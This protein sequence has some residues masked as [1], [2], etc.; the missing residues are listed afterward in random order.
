MLMA[1]EAKIAETLAK[2]ATSAIQGTESAIDMIKA[3][4]IY[5]TKLMENDETKKR[6]LDFYNVGLG[7]EGKL[8]DGEK[9]NILSYSIDPEYAKVFYNICKRDNIGHL[10]AQSYTMDLVVDGK[11]DSIKTVNDSVWIYNTQQKQF[12]NAIAEAKSISGYEVEV[13]R[14]VAEV[15]AKKQRLSGNP[16]RE[17][18]NMPI[19]RYVELRKDIQKLDRDMR[20]TLFPRYH[21][22]PETGKTLVDV[23]FLSKTQQLYDKKG[24]TIENPKSYNIQEVMKGLC[25][26]MKLLEIEDL[27][28]GYFEKL[29]TKETFKQNTINNM[30][31]YKKDCVKQIEEITKNAK[32]TNEFS[33]RMQNM[34]GHY[35]KGMI[36]TGE[37][38]DF[39]NKNSINLMDKDKEAV[40]K[41]LNNIDN[42]RYIFPLKIV[43][44]DKGRSYEIE[45]NQSICYSDNLI[46]RSS[47]KED[48]IIS[49]YSSYKN[50]LDKALI[51][52][53][54]RGKSTE[55]DY[56]FIVLNREELEK[57][58]KGYTDL[59]RGDNRL[60]LE[61]IEFAIENKDMY[62]N[63]LNNKTDRQMT[64][65]EIVNEINKKK[66]R[67]I[68][69]TDQE[70][71][72]ADRF[73]EHP[74]AVI[75]EIIFEHDFEEERQLE[76]FTNAETEGR[77]QAFD[78][79]AELMEICE[80]LREVEFES[81]EG[82]Y[83]DNL[84]KEA[85]ERLRDEKKKEK[86]QE[87]TEILP[88]I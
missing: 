29:E 10:N 58:E 32:I 81:A 45:M 52:M 83:V 11:G 73:D 44:H 20:F 13:P 63:E 3:L 82:Q 79:K 64:A 67:F 30:L 33:L 8:A 21:K 88:E 40:L 19:E 86:T 17:I 66:E 1:N 37:M 54:E 68:L 43:N 65:E 31:N 55:H 39:I 51:E 18:K 4:T 25:A 36:S 5:F 22:D 75:E 41:V 27:E 53:T 74:K 28:N 59:I 6:L 71:W 57:I 2:Y 35:N 76:D 48:V 7:E 23:G 56:T 47:G 77:Q 46:V 72:M 42:E 87:K 14:E 26:K 70:E 62:S 34:I 61:N 69:E 49:D 85:E 15:F 80:E 60:V 84:I 9:L 78:K 24:N 38:I 50:N 16:M 12:M